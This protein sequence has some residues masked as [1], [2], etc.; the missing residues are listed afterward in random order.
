MFYH[1]P[2]HPAQ[3][4]APNSP[5][6]PKKC[7]GSSGTKLRPL[8]L[9]GGMLGACRGRKPGLG[10][11]KTSRSTFVCHMS[12]PLLRIQFSME[13]TLSPGLEYKLKEP[14]GSIIQKRSGKGGTCAHVELSKWGL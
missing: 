7:P 13:A 11:R 5:K 8:C 3:T 6:S 12:W 10:R 4:T 2:S 1:L 9:R 14:G